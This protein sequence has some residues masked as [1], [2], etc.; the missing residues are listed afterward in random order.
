MTTKYFKT[1]NQIYSISGRNFSGEPYTMASNGQEI[2]KEEFEYLS[3]RRTGASTRSIDYFIQELFEQGETIIVDHH[4]STKSHKWLLHK[5]L[6]RLDL[7][8]NHIMNKLIVKGLTI[9][10]K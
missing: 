9:K 4:D 5:V 2:T 1:N 6:S 8:H 10:F 7:E 3:E